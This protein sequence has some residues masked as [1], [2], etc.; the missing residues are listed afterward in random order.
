MILEGKRAIVTGGAQGMGAAAVKKFAAEGSYVASV[1]ILD[2]LAQEFA[3]SVNSEHPGKVTTYHADVSQRDQVQQAFAAAVAQLGGLD[4]LVNA[5][6]VQNARPCVELTDEML[7]R[8]ISINLK[9]TMITNQTAYPYI[10]EAGGGSILNFGSDAGLTGIKGMTGYGSTKAAIMSWSRAAA[11]E[12]GA[13]N[14]RVNSIVPAIVTPMTL[15][16]AAAGRGNIYSGV[17][18]GGHLGDADDD[19]APVAAFLVSDGAKFITGQVIVVNGGL[20]FSR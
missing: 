13:D 8:L 4:I 16:G 12:W 20:G 14:V 3:A 18:L 1:D 15:A 17:V 10:K 5:A 7:D 11:V 19:F 6:G 2:E 9:G